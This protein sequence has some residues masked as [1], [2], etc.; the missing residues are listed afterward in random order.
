[1]R[2]KESL[3]ASGRNQREKL[4]VMSKGGENLQAQT[5]PYL[6]KKHRI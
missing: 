3:T 2:G 5:T 4:T 1:M 6:A